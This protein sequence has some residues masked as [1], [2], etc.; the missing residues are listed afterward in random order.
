[1]RNRPTAFEAF[2]DGYRFLVLNENQ[3]EQIVDLETCVL[4]IS[5]SPET[6]LE[7]VPRFDFDNERVRIIFGR[8][9][10]SRPLY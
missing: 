10:V 4:E 6:K 8:E 3:W 7:I 1:M 9:P 2:Q 5:P